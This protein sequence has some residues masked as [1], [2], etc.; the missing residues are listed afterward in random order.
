MNFIKDSQQIKLTNDYSKN[1]MLEYYTSA[2]I[3]FIIDLSNNF[4]V[5][6]DGL[7]RFPIVKQTESYSRTF[8][9]IDENSKLMLIIETI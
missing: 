9:V 3:Y 5:V 7:S 8:S 6:L 4:N 1:V 2:T